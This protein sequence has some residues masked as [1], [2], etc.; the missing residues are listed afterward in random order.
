MNKL[1]LILFFA[2]VGCK[3]APQKSL[4]TSP[5]NAP[6]AG[7]TGTGTKDTPFTREVPNVA[8]ILGPG[9]AKALAHAG[10]I[11]ALQENH[12]PINKII[13]IEWGS[14][15]AAAF[16][17]HG[18]FHEVDWKL[19]RLDQVDLNAKGLFGL[20][21]GDRTIKI[22]DGYLKENFGT[23]DFNSLKIPFS[24]PTRNYWSGALVMQQRG[25]L[26]D[27]LRKCLPFPPLFQIRGNWV[28]GATASRQI[29]D[30]LKAENVRLVV[31]VDVL[32]S[33]LPFEKEKLNDDP[34]SVILWQEVQRSIN[35]AQSVASETIRV[36]TDNIFL[37]R[38]NA[39]K[40][41]T[42]AGEQ[43]GVRAAQ[44]LSA[45]YGF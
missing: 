24:C 38:F 37:D 20:G 10:V 3:T 22:L 8:V 29:V 27:G 4:P 26:S 5:S 16:A 7:T 13:G 21:R 15:I 18:Q 6:G 9:G 17:M 28:A 40:E 11:K 12:I 23:A 44:R 32:G 30:Q 1:I 43:E 33:A 14:L 42:Q 45:K 36:S 19:Y 41:L 39:R 34:N 31:F 35:D 2:F 25:V